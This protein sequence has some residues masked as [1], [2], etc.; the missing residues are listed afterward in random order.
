MSRA[1]AG[2]RWHREIFADLA[3]M[4]PGRV[5]RAGLTLFPLPSTRTMA[6]SAHDVAGALFL[7][8]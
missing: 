7:L 3:A 1:N 2:A 8:A 6:T 5:V 4:L